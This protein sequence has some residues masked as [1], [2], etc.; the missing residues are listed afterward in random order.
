MPA[1]NGAGTPG[2]RRLMASETDVDPA[3]WP[4]N[5]KVSYSVTGRISWGP[6]AP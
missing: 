5:T 2:S 4:C 3:E 6:Y 1:R